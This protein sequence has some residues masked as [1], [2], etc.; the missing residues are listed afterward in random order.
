MIKCPKCYRDIENNEANFCPY[1]SQPL[2]GGL[3]NI[4]KGRKEIHNI[5]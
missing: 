4:K 5:M 1:C 3:E 2:K